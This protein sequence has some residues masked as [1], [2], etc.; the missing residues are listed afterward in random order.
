MRADG[1]IYY[2]ILYYILYVCMSMCTVHCT[3][4][5]MSIDDGLRDDDAGCFSLPLEFP[6]RF[7]LRFYS[8]SHLFQRRIVC[9]ARSEPRAKRRSGFH[10][11]VR[12]FGLDWIG[13]GNERGLERTSLYVRVRA[14][15]LE[16]PEEM[17]RMGW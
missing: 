11:H 10:V 15:G 2:I 4:S 16:L 3:Y 5:S 14:D 13:T 12:D 6:P 17:R 9:S 1:C 8:T 7:V